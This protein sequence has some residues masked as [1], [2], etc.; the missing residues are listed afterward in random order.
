LAALDMARPLLL[1][2]G[3][4]RELR[5]RGVPLLDTIW[6]ANGLVAAP[7]VVRQIHSDYIQAGADVITTNTYGLIRIDL[8]NEGIEDRFAELNVLAC[9]LA[10]EAREASERPVMIAG[11]LPPLRGSYRPDLVGPLEEIRPLY[12]E[13]AKLL[14]VHVDLLLCETMSS[15]AEALAAASAAA[16]TGLPVWVSFTLA[17][18]GLGELRSGE[19]VADVLDQLR[20][21][22]IEGV[23]ANCCTPESIGAAM[24]EMVRSGKPFTGGYANTFQPVPE[25]WTLESDGLLPTR[26]DLDAEAYAAHAR[27]WL[28]AGATVA[29]GCCGTGPRHIARLRRLLDESTFAT[30]GL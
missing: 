18:S 5:A 3:M 21:L 29:G 6:S 25:E 24:P 12:D 17:D 13:Q 22:P 16:E 7:D 10:R 2:G 19:S 26:D 14:A 4:G 8:A 9:M 11:S 1:D 15:G 20:D 27:A 28:E 23:L 30:K